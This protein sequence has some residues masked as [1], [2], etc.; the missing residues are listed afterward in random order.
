[1]FV[2]QSYC[3]CAAEVDTYFKEAGHIRSNSL[4]LSKRFLFF[5]LIS[6]SLDVQKNVSF[7]ATS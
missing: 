2:V 6:Q 5:V 1:M 7:F 3:V 4:D